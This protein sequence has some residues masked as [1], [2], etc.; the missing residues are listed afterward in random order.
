MP[1]ASGHVDPAQAYSGKQLKIAG[2]LLMLAGWTIVVTAV[3]LLRTPMAKTAFVLA[4]AAIEILGFVLVARAHLPH[5]RMS[6]A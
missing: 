3:L 6:D 4:G 5:R 2:F 1:K